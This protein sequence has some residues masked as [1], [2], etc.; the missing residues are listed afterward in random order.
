MNS[1][2]SQIIFTN[3]SP[4]YLVHGKNVTDGEGNPIKVKAVTALCRCGEST[5]MP[6]CDNQHEKN[7]L[8]TKKSDER[9]PDK[10]KSYKGENITIHFNL[11]LCCHVASC[12]KG[13]PS[14]FN[15]DERPWINADGGTT[16]EIIQIIS[17]CPSGALTYT[18]DGRF[19]SDFE[20]DIHIKI[21]KNGPIVVSGAVELIDDLES[22][23]ELKARKRYTLCR[24]NNSK[25]KPFCDGSHIP[26]HEEN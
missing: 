6:Y 2:K 16:E 13:L 1:K 5:S 25:N 3:N 11:G 18:K 22:M 21:M 9:A 14:V 26:K 24:C 8:N 20:K 19:Y 17:K 10:W 12:I 23:Q 15:V 4:F 7:K